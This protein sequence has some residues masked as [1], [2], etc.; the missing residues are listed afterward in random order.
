M[1]SRADALC[2]GNRAKSVC[3]IAQ[4]KCVCGLTRITEY[5][6][7]KNKGLVRCSVY[8]FRTQYCKVSEMSQ[9]GCWDAGRDLSEGNNSIAQ[10][11]YREKEV[12]FLLSSLQGNFKDPKCNYPN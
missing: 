8:K 11:W 5:L 2:M 4:F 10:L 12:K 1:K 9:V 7:H 3:C 6:Q